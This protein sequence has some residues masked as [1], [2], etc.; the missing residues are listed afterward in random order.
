MSE[1]YFYLIILVKIYNVIYRVIKII[2]FAFVGIRFLGG[3]YLLLFLGFLD[4]EFIMP[5]VRNAIQEFM[6]LT[7]NT[8]TINYFVF[9]TRHQIF[10]YGAGS[11]PIEEKFLPRNSSGVEYSSTSITPNVY[12]LIIDDL[13]IAIFN[14]LKIVVLYH[15]VFKESKRF[16]KI[17]KRVKN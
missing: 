7:I 12:S 9:L 11:I 10:D 14:T 3:F 8:Q 5:I 16:M 1:S 15:L 17:L 13:F 4:L 2:G 6:T